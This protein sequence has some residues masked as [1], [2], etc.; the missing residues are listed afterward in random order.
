MRLVLHHAE[1][2][3]SIFFL[4]HPDD[5]FGIFERIRR[6]RLENTR[7]LF[8]FCTKTKKI[9]GRRKI[10]SLKVLSY[11]GVAEE[12]CIFLSDFV[13]IEDGRAYAYADCL[14]QIIT[15]I[16][17][18]LPNLRS[19]HIPAFEGGHQDHDILHGL[20]CLATQKHQL[21]AEIWQSFLY[22]AWNTGWIFFKVC[23][24]IDEDS[25]QKITLKIPIFFRIIYLFLC[26]QYQSQWRTWIGILP[27]LSF[28]YLRN[29]NETHVKVKASPPV[30][31]WQRP[32][33]GKLLYESR[34][35]CSF[36]KVRF[37][38][39][40]ISRRYLDS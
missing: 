9:S 30:H 8:V 5:E 23:N 36:K 16:F 35:V 32:H 24:I 7:C 38:L 40:N 18:Q 31:L 19:I 2:T 27:F 29:G 22:N 17:N 28:H 14:F 11:F 6:L 3:E 1:T 33:P 37:A 10:E 4:A 15:K 12:E 20:V 13:N 21:Q 39:K 25:H 26:L 34:E